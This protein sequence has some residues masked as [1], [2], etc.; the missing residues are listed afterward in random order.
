M[1]VQSSNEK[2]FTSTE[3]GKGKVPDA[4]YANGHQ[5]L[6]RQ[7][8]SDP[9]KRTSTPAKVNGE[10]EAQIRDKAKS[11]TPVPSAINP[12]A[13]GLPL[14]HADQAFADRM[15]VNRNKIPL[16]NMKGP[17]PVWSNTRKGL[18]SAL[19]YMR[20]P[21]KTGG[22]SVDISPGGMARGV[23]L[24]GQSPSEIMYWGNEENAGTLM[25]P[26]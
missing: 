11:T 10:G 12:A 13:A 8:P 2:R 20:N 26:M 1:P 5:P 3:K 21:T 24:E 22:A 7:T 4:P 25:L 15:E 6:I 9:Q 19:E 16:G 23:I 17:C 18:Q 14:S